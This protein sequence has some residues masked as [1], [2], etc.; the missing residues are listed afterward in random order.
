MMNVLVVEKSSE[1]RAELVDAVCELPGV[2]VRAAAANAVDADLVL[3]SEYIEAVVLGALPA[4]QRKDVLANVHA[5]CTV[6]DAIDTDT[7]GVSRRLAELARHRD[8]LVAAS[9]T[10]TSLTSHARGIARQRNTV[11]AGPLAL[12][13]QLRLADPETARRQACRMETLLLADWLPAAI[14]RMRP[15][16]PDIIEIVPVIAADTPPVWCMPEVI[17][18]ALLLAVLEAAAKLPWGGTI[19]LAVDRADIRVVR[20]DVIENGQGTVH[21]VTI[22][23]A[24]AAAS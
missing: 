18:H 13:L 6:I 21:D 15:A 12:S 2:D 19:W 24:T 8:Q 1:R 4:K 16:V 23:A 11:Q 14:Q 9:S 17:E 22:R 5:T 10:F 7:D 20:I 3:R